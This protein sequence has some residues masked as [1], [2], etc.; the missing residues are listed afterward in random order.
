MRIALTE[1]VHALLRADILRRPCNR[2]HAG[3]GHDTL[4]L[5]E[6]VGEMGQVF[7]FDLTP[8]GRD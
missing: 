2:C 6:L 7:A 4:L 1:Q 5:A 8:S 3:N